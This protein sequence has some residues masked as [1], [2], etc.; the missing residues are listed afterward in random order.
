MKIIKRTGKEEKYSSIKIKNVIRLACTNISEDKIANI[1]KN[2]IEPFIQDGMSVEYIQDL[3]E[4]SLMKNNEYIGAKKYIIYRAEKNML[5][6]RL[7]YMDFYI[8]NKENAATSS[9]EDSNS[10][11]QCKNVANLNGETFKTLNRKLQRMWMKRELNS[12]FENNIAHQY[13]K[14]IENHIIYI[15]DESSFPIPSNYC[16]AVSLYPLLLDGTHNMDGLNTVPPKNLDSF[17]GQLVNLTFLLASQ[18]KGAVAF[19]EFF[20]FFDYFCV[21]EFGEDYTNNLNFVYMRSPNGKIKTIKDRILQAFQQIIYSW[22][23][24]AGNRSYQSPFI[25]I[26]YYDSG[27]WKALFENFAFP[28]GSIPSWERVNV[29]Q[30]MFMKWFN[31]E[32]KKTLLTF[33]VETMAL[34]T[35]GKNVIDKEYKDFSAE[36]WSEGHSFFMYISDNPNGLSSCCRLRN[37][38]EENVF[39]FTNGLSGVKTGS[40]NVITLNLNR[41]VQNI[42]LEKIPNLKKGTQFSFKECDWELQKQYIENGLKEIL[43]RVYKYQIAYKNL[44]YK[45]ESMGML[46]ACTAGY[47]DIQSLFSTIGINGLNE[48]AE[49]LG[50]ICTDNEK[51]K[52]FCNLITGTISSENKKHLSQKYKF[53]QEMVPAEQLGSRNCNWDRE[54]GYWVPEGRI[55]YNSYFYKADDP[56]ISVL[57][58]FVLHG[59]EYTNK[60]DGGMG[61][62]CNLD[63]NLSKEQYLKLIDWAITQGTF[64]FTFNV[65]QSECLDCKK[66]VKIPVEKCPFCGS[67]NI[68]Q[69]TRVI[70]Y[71]RPISGFDKY[72]KRE[73]K[74]RIYSSTI[75]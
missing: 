1:L 72:R 32:R 70:G 42:F 68:Q 34:L 18:C 41:I 13:I 4:K 21:K 62:H 29:L 73:A 50:L 3:V 12:S 74:T 8:Q 24:P 47:I 10:N 7:E 67:T 60:M 35:D 71:L 31:D 65:P 46:T 48:A 63:T 40:V 9:E 55:L 19:G 38:L 66:I 2:D 27:Y 53:N 54:D 17:C 57:K 36:M 37:E 61:L 51:Y 15:H 20:N 52:E 11:V 44:V 75:C 69:W 6:S 33:P 28:D 45:M 30:K 23:Q 43:D 64:Y 49:Y 26:S 22:N 5:R 16:E 39:S 59:K 56:D 25:N 14:D 58:K